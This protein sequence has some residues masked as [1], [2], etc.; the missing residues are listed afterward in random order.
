[1]NKRGGFFLRGN[2]IFCLI[3]FDKETIFAISNFYQ[4]RML[5]V[6]N[7]SFGYT[8]KAIIK[9]IN[10]T[11][12]KGQNIAIIGESG[13]GKSTLLKLIYGLYDLDEG[14]IFWNETQVLG[15]KFNLIPGMPF[16]K[17]MAQDFDLMPYETVAEN[18]GKFLIQCFYAFKKTPHSGITG[19]C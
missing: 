17:Y 16:M 12:N 18:I 8:D 13:C 2:L 6:Q 1:M 7:I 14:H 9:N 10:F 15:P 5:Q 11:V 19:N 3:F 4:L